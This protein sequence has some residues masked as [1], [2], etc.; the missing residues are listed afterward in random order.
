MR[1]FDEPTDQL[2]IRL[3]S[4]EDVKYIMNVS[5]TADWN[6]S[7]AGSYYQY[8]SLYS[9]FVDILAYYVYHLRG[10]ASDVLATA[11]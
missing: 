5:T 8:G 6:E 4:L 2:C 9:F 7:F 11:A 3:R 1:Y 10:C